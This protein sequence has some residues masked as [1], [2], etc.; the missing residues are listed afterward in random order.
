V[1]ARIVRALPGDYPLPILVVQHIA[2]GFE[3]GLVHWLQCET[4]LAVKLAADGDPLRP[5]TVYVAPDGSHLVPASGRVSLVGGAPVRGFRPSGTT[6]LE[7][8]ASEY[9]AG[10]AGVV[11][12]GMGDDGAA[13]LRAVRERG[14][15]TAAQGPESSVVFGMPRVAIERGAARRVLEADEIAPALV[16]L[17]AASRAA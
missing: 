13:G 8:M 7:A 12:S 1:L 15:W 5:G 11:L 14:G 9:G 4:R 10:A 3:A 2:H 6:L 17:A 16:R